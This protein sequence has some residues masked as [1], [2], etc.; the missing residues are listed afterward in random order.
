M[1]HPEQAPQPINQDQDFNLQS[2]LEQF[3]EDSLER[4]AL[5]Y[6]NSQIIDILGRDEKGNLNDIETV[7][8]EKDLKRLK[9]LHEQWQELL[10]EGKISNEAISEVLMNK[11]RLKEALETSQSL[12]DELG[13]DV[14]LQEQ[15]KQGKIL[16]PT[17]EQIK[18]AEQLELTKTLIIPAGVSQSQIIEAVE[19]KYQELGNGTYFSDEAKTHLAEPKVKQRHQ[20]IPE[21]GHFLLTN[22]AREVS[23]AH[24]ETMNKTP[25][26]ILDQIKNLNQE[27][28][29]ANI[30][31]LALAEYLLLQAQTSLET[32]NQEHL[33]QRAYSWLTEELNTNQDRCLDAYWG[34]RPGVYSSAVGLH[35]S[36]RGARLAAVPSAET[37]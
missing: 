14:N 16:L 25:S 11:E 30:R 6:L 21:Q 17:S 19:A 1:P 5:E 4:E 24:P 9:A 27:N 3:D 12:Y 22:P 32:D 7:E 31:G 2:N 15:L 28:P 34:D 20:R 35:D 26:Q 8:D 33:E 29:K 18:Q 10:E 36:D 23:E 37:R 13:I